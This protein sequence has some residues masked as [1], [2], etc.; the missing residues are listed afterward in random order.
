MYAIHEVNGR[1]NEQERAQQQQKQQERN[2]FME[3]EK[4]YKYF[5]VKHKE[6]TL[7]FG[8]FAY[9][10]KSSVWWNCERI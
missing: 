6:H 1:R 4:K 10:G 9:K 2:E 3:K 8:V 5:A 7:S